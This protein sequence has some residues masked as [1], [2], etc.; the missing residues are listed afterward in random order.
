MTMPDHALHR[1]ARD[2]WQ[3]LCRLDPGPHRDGGFLDEGTAVLT[4]DHFALRHRPHRGLLLLRTSDNVVKCLQLPQTFPRST[5]TSTNSWGRHPWLEP[6]R[7]PLCGP[8]RLTH[9]IDFAGA[10]LAGLPL[11]S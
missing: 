4:I 2:Q 5:F 11:T 3:R 6:P 9:T 8:A 1:R 7:D 10:L